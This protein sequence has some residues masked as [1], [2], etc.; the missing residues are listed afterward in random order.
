MLDDA[1]SN[2]LKDGRQDVNMIETEGLKKSFGTVRALDGL[3]LA[4]P[5]GSVCALLGP[6]GAG[7]TTAIRVLATLTRP[8]AGSARIAGQDVVRHPGQVRRRIG[9]AGQH[10]AVDD[11][12]TGRE[13][14][15]ILGLM[16][17]LG[18][19]GARQRADALLAQFGLADAADRLVKTWSGGMRRRLDL[20]A[21]LVVAP[22]V[23]F[24]DEPTTGLDPRSR[25]EIWAT[26][27][28][29]ASGGTTIL[30]TTQHLD[31]ADRLASYVVIIDAGRV[32]AHGRPA[33]LKAAIGTRIDVV[34]GTAEDL[35]VA[36]AVLSRWATHPPTV[37]A[38]ERRL[39]APVAADAVTLPELVRQLD[40][41]GV[42]AEDVS[43]RRPTLDE[44]F[45]N[46][47]GAAP[48]RAAG[49]ETAA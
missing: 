33:T 20:L 1:S 18:R 43:V 37:E 2:P 38:G 21:S 10:A 34:T 17:H 27:R 5:G 12:L 49:S 35:P 45:L 23:L 40:A 28:T 11:D 9:L 22:P 6:N 4:V 41:A 36:V 42:Q 29:L 13:N 48:A 31:E 15:F 47:T 46:R 26:I 44:V 25:A 39:T 14:L 19:R 16:Y 3:D 30:L 8:D 32:T 24:L 7:K